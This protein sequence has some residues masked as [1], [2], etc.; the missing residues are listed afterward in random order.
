MTTHYY[1]AMRE[2]LALRLL[3]IRTSRSLSRSE[4]ARRV[5][6]TAPAIANYEANRREP[7]LWVLL[8]YAREFDLSLD[9]L[10]QND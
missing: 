9:T 8:G 6:A 7:P 3:D 4:I 5:G 1:P 10:V 2:R